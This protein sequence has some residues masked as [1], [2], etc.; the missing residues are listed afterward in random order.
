MG[1]FQ[2]RE[3]Y[4]LPPTPALKPEPSDES[5]GLTDLQIELIRSSWEKVLPNK[6][7]HGE[8]LFHK[9]FEIAPELKDLFPF[10]N[11]F[12]SPQFT[13]HALNVINAVD[14]AVKHLDK[15]DILIPKLKELGQMHAAFELTAKEFQNVGQALI[16]VLA[17]GLGDN[18]TPKLK[19][20]WGDAYAIITDVMLGAINDINGSA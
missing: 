4:E 14:L 11:D 2:S 16:W 15:P 13:M 18:F 19:R 7:H 1:I 17:T 5:D 20:A 3:S 6:K 9:L 10:G 8:L 12:T